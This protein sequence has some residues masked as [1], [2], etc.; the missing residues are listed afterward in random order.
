MNMPLL[1]K[2]SN[3]CNQNLCIIAWPF[4]HEQFVFAKVVRQHDLSI[5]KCGNSVAETG[6]LYSTYRLLHNFVR[7]PDRHDV[8]CL[9]Y[10]VLTH[11]LVGQQADT[12]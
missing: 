10:V 2:S 5:L 11:D 4:G 7:R 6:L 8:L 3:F 9:N 12:I 1:T